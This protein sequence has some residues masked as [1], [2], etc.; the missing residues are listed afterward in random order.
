ML[1]RVKTTENKVKLL[2]M[3]VVDT[4]IKQTIP[5]G[6]SKISKISLQEVSHVVHLQFFNQKYSNGNIIKYKN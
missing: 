1:V 3:K 4:G 6:V 2:K 5:V